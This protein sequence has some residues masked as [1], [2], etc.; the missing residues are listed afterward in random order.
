[1]YPDQ[2]RVPDLISLSAAG[3]SERISCYDVTRGSRCLVANS[4]YL[5]SAHVY[6]IE[7]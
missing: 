3:T 7:L 6:I 5:A 1:M 2:N 4:C